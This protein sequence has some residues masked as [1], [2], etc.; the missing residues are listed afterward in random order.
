MSLVPC[1]P[2]CGDSLFRFSILILAHTP[3]RYVRW[4]DAYALCCAVCVWWITQSRAEGRAQQRAEKR[5]EEK[6]AEKNTEKNTEKRREEK[7]GGEREGES[8]GVSHTN[9]KERR[10]R[11]RDTYI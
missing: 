11:G 1:F 8:I 3:H 2:V 6:R 10:K 9:R 5:R 4:T 7:R